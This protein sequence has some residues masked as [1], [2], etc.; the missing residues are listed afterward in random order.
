MWVMSAM[1]QC[2][3]SSSSRWRDLE[4]VVQLVEVLFRLGDQPFEAGHRLARDLAVQE[5]G[6]LD[7]LAVDQGVQ[8]D[9]DVPCDPLDLV[10]ARLPRTWPQPGLERLLVRG[11]ARRVTRSG[12][13]ADHLAGE[14]GV[15][16]CRG[17]RDVVQ[18]GRLVEGHLA[19][20][21]GLDH[22][23][24][25]VQVFATAVLDRGGEH[26]QDGRP[27]AVQVVEDRP[28]LQVI[29]DAVEDVRRA[30][31]RRADGPA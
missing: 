31:P 13:T 1:V 15:A 8:A 11:I 19:G 10:D 12:R 24:A 26:V 21:G 9:F 2:R 3:S 16:S 29:V 30:P 18:D 17:R 5:L 6:E 23:Q 25:A 4:P 27:F 28:A 7:L 20:G 22:E 14:T